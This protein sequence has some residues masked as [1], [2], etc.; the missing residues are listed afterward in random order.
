MTFYLTYAEVVW[1]WFYKRSVKYKR[2]RDRNA[3]K[4]VTKLCMFIVVAQNSVTA[5][6]RDVKFEAF[7][8]KTLAIPVS[9]FSTRTSDVQIIC[10]LTKRN[11]FKYHHL[12]S[13]TCQIN[14][15]RFDTVP[16]MAY[17]LKLKRAFGLCL[18]SFPMWRASLRISDASRTGTIWRLSSK[19]DTHRGAL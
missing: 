2:A 19:Q 18:S 1:Q 17:Q 12:T 5:V 3:K 11:T 13:G 16:T 15:L 4:F 6:K 9:L 10:V 7:L 8:L 14:I